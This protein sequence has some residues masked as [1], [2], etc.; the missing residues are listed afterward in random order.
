M[1]LQLFPVEDFPVYNQKVKRPLRMN[2]R[3][4]SGTAQIYNGE[5]PF[6]NGQN[7]PFGVYCTMA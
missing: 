7:C 6:S 5:W 2:N 4:R 1:A 3:F